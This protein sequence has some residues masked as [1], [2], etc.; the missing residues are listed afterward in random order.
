[1]SLLTGPLLF[2][3]IAFAPAASAADITDRSVLTLRLVKDTGDEVR[4]GG[5]DSSRGPQ[6][7]HRQLLVDEGRQPVEVRPAR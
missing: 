2:A 6:Q 1:M 3:A 5:S 4:H 7:R